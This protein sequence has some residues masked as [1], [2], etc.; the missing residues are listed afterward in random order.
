LKPQPKKYRGEKYEEV[1]FDFSDTSVTAI[2]PNDQ[3]AVWSPRR[4]P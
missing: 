3:L 4:R 1:T 2:I